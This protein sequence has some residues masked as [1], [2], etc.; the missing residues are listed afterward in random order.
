MFLVFFPEKNKG[1]SLKKSMTD[2]QDQRNYYI[3][4]PF[5]PGLEDQAAT[6][7]STSYAIPSV[8][9]ALPLNSL[10]FRCNHIT[11]STMSI[12][13]PSSLLLP[14]LLWI[15]SQKD[16]SKVV[17]ISYW[18]VGFILSWQMGIRRK[19]VCNLPCHLSIEY[20]LLRSSGTNT[21][22]ILVS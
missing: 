12:R 20:K 5:S 16:V 11:Q 3:R 22:G 4:A 21:C 1:R 6:K 19:D 7:T 17:F 14:P 2:S 15:D 18:F 13:T 8:E 9:A 10:S